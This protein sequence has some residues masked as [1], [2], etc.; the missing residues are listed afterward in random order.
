MAQPNNN[1]GAL[2]DSLE[3]DLASLRQKVGRKTTTKRAGKASPVCVGRRNSRKGRQATS[4]K[5]VL[6]E[7]VPEF[8]EA[9]LHELDDALMVDQENRIWEEYDTLAFQADDV[10]AL[11]ELHALEEDQVAE[12]MTQKKGVFECWRKHAFESLYPDLTLKS[13]DTV[14]RTHPQHDTFALKGFAQR[15]NLRTRRNL[16][17]RQRVL[18]YVSS[19]VEGAGYTTLEFNG[20]DND[21][22]SFVEFIP[23][24]KRKHPELEIVACVSGPSRAWHF[25]KSWAPLQ[26]KGGVPMT[27][28]VC[29]PLKWN[30]LGDYAL[31]LFQTKLVLCIGGGGVVSSER[32]LEIARVMKEPEPS[33]AV[34]HQFHFT[35]ANKTGDGEEECGLKDVPC[36]A[37]LAHHPYINFEEV[38][39][40]KSA[41]HMNIGAKSGP[42]Q[43]EDWI[44][45]VQS[46]DGEFSM[47]ITNDGHGGSQQ[48]AREL[49][50]SARDVLF[51]QLVEYV[52]GN[53]LENLDDFGKIVKSWEDETYDD[54]RAKKR[55]FRTGF[56]KVVG[57]KDGACVSFQFHAPRT[58]ALVF[59]TYGD[60]RAAAFDGATGEPVKCQQSR[61]DL[62]YPEPTVENLGIC[63]AV[64]EIHAFG[65]PGMVGLEKTGFVE[66]RSETFI[67]TGTKYPT[68]E[69]GRTVPMFVKD[70]HMMDRKDLEKARPVSCSEKDMGCVTFPSDPSGASKREWLALNDYHYRT[71]NEDWK[72][73]HRKF[74][75]INDSIKILES[76]KERILTMEGRG[77]HDLTEIE[78]HLST[79]YDQKSIVKAAAQV[80]LPSQYFIG[81]PDV[82][83]ME[84]VP[85]TDV[86]ARHI[87]FSGGGWRAVDNG[88]QPSRT[89]EP[90][91][92]AGVIKN[93][94]LTFC[95]IPTD[96][97]KGMF[98]SSWSDGLEDHGSSTVA[99]IGKQMV[100]PESF[101]EQWRTRPS[102]VPANLEDSQLEPPLEE[103]QVRPEDCGEMM[104]WYANLARYPM[105]TCRIKTPDTEWKCALEESFGCLNEWMCD[106]RHLEDVYWNHSQ[107]GLADLA[108]MLAHWATAKG[109]GDNAS[110]HITYYQEQ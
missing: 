33:Y 42:A 96:D 84:V 108:G 30:E 39:V 44:G 51:P 10:E 66:R 4:K 89:V 45:D 86:R 68:H 1:F 94:V 19:L 91:A 90:D 46:E 27:V 38:P 31:E 103:L 57:R 40:R 22:N 109:S 100:F 29:P 26:K 34:W 9:E 95:H 13:A 107:S 104:G 78:G 18:N 77:S 14:R 24:I 71:I 50:E 79:L 55:E 74:T 69:I 25:A 52:R 110:I 80:L 56:E 99:E 106:Q 2:A 75:E 48:A 17:L 73:S 62:S 21:E 8:T 37:I 54:H 83:T 63:E 15:M 3:K 59:Y 23:W 28:V 12:Q 5:P 93:G 60:C 47:V 85:R 98:V 102:R 65:G 105:Y 36:S 64:S 81:E 97:W 101:G 49:G 70:D 43:Q 88:L 92:D 53:G 61:L 41:W 16:S 58:G 67:T 6:P 72:R 20:D 87:K 32:E 35:R 76:E 11:E 7:V 82:E